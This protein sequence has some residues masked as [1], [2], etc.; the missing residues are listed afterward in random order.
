MGSVVS[1]NR[2]IASQACFCNLKFGRCVPVGEETE[3]D[4]QVDD[5]LTKIE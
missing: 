2:E 5:G 1:T 4:T 3:G